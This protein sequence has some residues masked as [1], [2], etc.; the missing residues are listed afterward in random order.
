[1]QKNRLIALNEF[2]NI[3]NI[4]ISFISSLQKNGLVKITTIKERQFVDKDQ[5][6]QLEK[7]VR[8][9]YELDINMEGIEAITHLL[10][11]MKSI[12]NEITV[13][14]NKLSFYEITD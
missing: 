2:C 4:E 10:E 12:Q 1:M 9:Y 11:R 8:F 6:R 3:H 14:K 7:I 5:L 13:L